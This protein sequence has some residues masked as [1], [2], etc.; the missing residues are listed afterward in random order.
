MEFSQNSKAWMTTDLFADYL[1]RLFPGKNQQHHTLLTL[2]TASA[3]G[4]RRTKGSL[5]LKISFNF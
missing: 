5:L 4:Y 2:D 3:H 1:K